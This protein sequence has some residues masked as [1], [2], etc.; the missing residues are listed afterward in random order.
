MSLLGGDLLHETVEVRKI[1]GPGAILTELHRGIRKQLRQKETSNR[2]GMDIALCTIDH[3][4][5]T[6]AFAGAKNPLVYIEGGEVH[7]IAGDRL[8]IGG[9]VKQ[10]ER[11]FTTRTIPFSTDTTFYIFSDGLQDQFGG[12]QGRKFGIKRLRELLLEAHTLPMP[13][14][15]ELIATTLQRWMLQGDEKQID[16]MLLL[17][18]RPGAV[19]RAEQPEPSEKAGGAHSSPFRPHPRQSP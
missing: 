12:S 8:T 2:D 4:S 17:G 6:L 1:T 18:F 16:D 13:Q 10:I 7:Q 19:A 9:R 11:E 3:H 5:R 15:K 14:Q